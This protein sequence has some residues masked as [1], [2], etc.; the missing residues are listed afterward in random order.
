MRALDSSL[1]ERMR[2][3]RHTHTH[4]GCGRLSL[5]HWTVDWGNATTQRFCLGLTVAA[6]N[7]WTVLYNM[8]IIS[9]LCGIREGWGDER[10]LH[11]D[12]LGDGDHVLLTCEDSL[13]QREV[14]IKP[15]QRNTND[16][17]KSN[18][19]QELQARIAQKQTSGSSH[20][21][22]IERRARAETHIHTLSHTQRHREHTDREPGRATHTQSPSLC[23]Q[24]H[25]LTFP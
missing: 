11:N 21:A 2:C 7:R 17:A 23:H 3:V 15:E 24:I 5:T 12:S 8:V 18:A 9:L 1:Q 16:T 13:V 10:R 22:S 25:E 4:W 14:T 20:N 19:V 6:S